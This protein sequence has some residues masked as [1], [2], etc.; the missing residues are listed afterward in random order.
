MS[1]KKVTATEMRATHKKSVVVENK[2]R[3]NEM[4]VIKRNEK[5]KRSN[6]ASTNWMRDRKKLFD[7][8]ISRALTQSAFNAA[9]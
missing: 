4:E 8:W 7:D 5:E 2:R 6:K 3:R 9:V 1:S